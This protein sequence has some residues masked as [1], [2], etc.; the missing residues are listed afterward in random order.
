M[1]TVAVSSRDNVKLAVFII[2]FTVFALSVGD[3]AIKLIS[4]DFPLWQIFVLRS[5]I[6][7]PILVC[8]IKAGARAV[9]L[10]PAHFGWTT[11]RSAMLVAMW[12]TYY[13]ALPHLALSV[14]AAAYYT[15]PLFITLFAALLLGETIGMKGWIAIGLG[16]C[17][18]LMILK[19]RAG[20]FNFYALLPLVSA[21]LYALAMI[22]TR[23]RCRDEHPLVLSLALNVS[24]VVA[25]LAASA[26]LV[27]F[28]A[29]L[30]GDGAGRFLTGSW[31]SM[32]QNEWLAMVLLTGAILIGSIGTAIAYQIG[33]PSIVATFDFAYVAFAAT[34][35][36]LVFAEM[37]DTLTLVGMALI[38][39]AG[40]LALRR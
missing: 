8:V 2:V 22:L 29:T 18:V 5:A 35:G 33:P 20:D 21:I 15:L 10:R 14:A 30:T 38:V 4:S 24:F 1:Q 36:F 31:I 7:L 6:A 27:L 17:G 34:W 26:W 32:G 3:A 25:G 40:V 23:T 12:V 16:F 39:G 28:P 37:P 11:L 13:A 19:P 9:A